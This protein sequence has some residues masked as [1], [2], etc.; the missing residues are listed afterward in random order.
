MGEEVVHQL[1]WCTGN[2][3]RGQMP[4]KLAILV[5]QAGQSSKGYFVENQANQFWSIGVP[6]IFKPFFFLSV[7]ITRTNQALYAETAEY[8]P[9]DII[10]YALIKVDERFHVSKEEVHR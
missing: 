9:L 1:E 7:H 4:Q 3:K 6:K 5:S 2:G 8:S 10:L